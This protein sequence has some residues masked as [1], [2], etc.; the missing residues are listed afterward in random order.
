MER[1][2][3]I[4]NNVIMEFEFKISILIDVNEKRIISE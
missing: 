3:L 4:I 1:Y 2:E